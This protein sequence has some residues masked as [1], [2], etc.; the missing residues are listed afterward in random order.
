MEGTPPDFDDEIDLDFDA[1]SQPLV[2][3][4]FEDELE[5]QEF[6]REPEDLPRPPKQDDSDDEAEKPP[7]SKSVWPLTSIPDFA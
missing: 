1:A 6:V 3:G 4:D 2:I 7:D 5:P